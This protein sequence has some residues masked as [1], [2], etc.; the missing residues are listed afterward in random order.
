MQGFELTKQHGQHLLAN[1]LVIKSIVEKAEIRSTDTVL[2]IGPGTG[3][4][5]LALLEKAKHVIAIEIDPRMVSELKKRIAA[6]PEYRG[7]FSI[8][9]KDFTKMPVS[10][11]PPF[12]LCVSNC[13]YNVSSGIVFRLL[14]IQP[15]PRKFV[16]MFQLEFAQRLAAE[17][18]QDQYSR[19]TVNTKLLSKTK[20]I[21]RVSRNSFKPPP[22]VDSAVVEMY[23]VGP[24][25]GLDLDEFNGLTRILFSKKNKTLGAIFKTKSL[26]DDLANNMAR[27]EEISRL[28]KP[29][30]PSQL[31]VSGTNHIATPNVC[32]SPLLTSAQIRE[33]IAEALV[34]TNLADTRPNHMAIP[35][36]LSL[37]CALTAKGVRFTN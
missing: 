15:L 22:N 14:E 20:I 31:E 34:E 16:L 23:P 2:E 37:M 9:C 18:G 25:P 24:P 11:I 1:P 28:H 35:D 7:K 6:I 29:P 4:L 19:L 36:L 10:E 8:I 17:P 27:L 5:T 33:R 3:N 21:I 12:D 26:L 32:N 30:Q 13:P